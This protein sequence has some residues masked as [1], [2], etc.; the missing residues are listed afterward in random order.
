[1]SDWFEPVAGFALVCLGLATLGLF[2]LVLKLVLS[3]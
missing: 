1:M 3:K 2:L